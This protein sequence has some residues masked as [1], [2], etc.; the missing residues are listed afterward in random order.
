MINLILAVVFS[1][2]CELDEEAPNGEIYGTFLTASGEVFLGD[3]KRD[4]T[5]VS[6]LLENDEVPTVI[7]VKPDGSYA[8]SI[9]EEGTYA[10]SFSGPFFP[11]E[12]QI[13]KVNGRVELDVNVIP[14]MEYELDMTELASTSATF[15]YKVK[16]NKGAQPTRRTLVWSELPNPTVYDYEYSGYEGGR[17]I[18]SDDSVM[19]DQN[20]EQS[21]I[22]TLSDLKANTT[23]YVRVGGRTEDTSVT[24]NT[25]SF[26]NYSAQIIIKTTN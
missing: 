13:L 8:R 18:D 24:P 21:G 17:M 11:I 22:Y 23:Y 12:D 14:F 9:L 5:T 26:Y 10:L 25:S 4:L 7:R 1:T 19:V 3:S 2:A 16:A 6:I 15:T 20:G